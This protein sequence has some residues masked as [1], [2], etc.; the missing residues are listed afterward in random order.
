M[1]SQ[2]TKSLWTEVSKHRHSEIEIVERLNWLIKANAEIEKSK[3]GT[4]GLQIQVAKSAMSHPMDSNQTFACLGL[5]LGTFPPA[6]FFVVFMSGMNGPSPAVAA[7]L[8]W[9]TSICGIAG[10][11]SGKLVSRMLD[12]LRGRSFSLQA[13]CVPMTGLIWGAI[14][15][16]AGGIFIFI[17]GA[18]FG[19]VLGAVVGAVALSAFY[20][21]FRLTANMGWIELKHFLPLAFGVTFTICAYILSLAA[22]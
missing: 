20:P 8:I 3:T 1:E 5:L 21:L 18:V 13:F 17:I 7:L 14:S 10:Y 16:A 15:G 9:V 19:A 4:S 2:K 6:S 22:F 11:Y 12:A